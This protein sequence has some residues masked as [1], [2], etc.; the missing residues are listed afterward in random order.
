MKFSLILCTIN[1]AN[2]VEEFLLSLNTQ[3]YKNFEVIIVDQNKDKR[4][5][6]ILDK[7][8]D[9]KI[10]HITSDIGLSKARNTGLKYADGEVIGFPDDDCTY[11]SDL[12]EN[13]YT[14]FSNTSYDFVLGKT[15][16]KDTGEIVAGKPYFKEKELNCFNFLGSSTTL[17]I[18]LK[19]ISLNMILFDEDFGLGAKYNSGEEEDLVF[20]LLHKKYKGFYDPYINF[21]YHPPSDLNYQDF[22]RAEYRSLG[23]GAFVIKHIFTLCGFNYFIKYTLLQPS[24]KI[25]K[26]C[27]QRDKTLCTFHFYRLAGIWKGIFFYINTK[28]QNIWSKS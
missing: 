26:S 4:L 24:V 6:N 1:R 27:I 18:S 10:K 28:I 9:L 17:F 13:I 3:T 14:F 5:V 25:A 21:V 12:L 2:E 22:K 7:F 20:R 15:I 16:D 19:N 11:P 23:L 8:K